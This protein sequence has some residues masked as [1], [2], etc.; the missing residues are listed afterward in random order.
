MFGALAQ[1][2]SIIEAKTS[3]FFGREGRESNLKRDF[4]LILL[5]SVEIASCTHESDSQVHEKS[6]AEARV[7]ARIMF[8]QHHFDGLV[9]NSALE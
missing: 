6:L 3:V 4:A 7:T 5:A 8:G 1:V 2:I 9:I